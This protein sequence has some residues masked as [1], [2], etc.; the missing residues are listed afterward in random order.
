LISEMFFA[1]IAVSPD[2]SKLSQIQKR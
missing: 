1:T 2:E